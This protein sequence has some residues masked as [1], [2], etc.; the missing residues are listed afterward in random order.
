M[1]ALETGAGHHARLISVLRE[2]GYSRSE[3]VADLAG[4]D[5][6]VLAWP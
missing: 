1:L 6:F 4:R 2:A 5:R 3:S